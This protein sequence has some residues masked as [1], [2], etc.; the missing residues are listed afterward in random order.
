MVITLLISLYTTRVILQVLGEVDY[1][2]Y[3]VVCGFVLMFSFL[4]S[5]MSNGIQRFF[6][7]EYGKNGEA[8]ANRVYCT[9]LYIQT[10]LALIAVVIVE[11]VGLWYLHNKMVIPEERI[12]A[13]EWIFQLSII[14]FVIGIMQAPYMAAVIAHERMDFY[15]VVNVIETVLKLGVVFL[16]KTINADKLITYGILTTLVCFLIWASYYTYCKRNFNEITFHKCLDK[17][18][19]RQMLGFSGWNLFGSFSNMMRDQGINMI[20]NFFFGPSVNAARGV[21]MQVNSGVY[22]LVLSILTPVRPQVLQ[23]YAKGDNDRVMNLTYTI[24]KFSLYFLLL[25]AMPLC[26]EIDFILRIW[27][28]D[29]I[30][31]HT[32]AF[33]III[34]LTSAILIPTSTQATLVHATGKMRTYQVIGGIAKVLSV[35]IAFVMLK[36][37]Y[38]PEWALIMVLLFDFI[39]M[40]VGMF[41]IRTLMPF[42]VCKYV[43]KVFFPIIPVAT[44]AFL[45]SWMTHS[46]IGNEIL[47]FLLVTLVSTLVI[48]L[49]IYLVGM[50]KDEKTL[51]VQ[52]ANSKILRNS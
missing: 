36:M 25:L 37:G 52:L 50:T 27:L 16:L 6:N 21:A 11:A 42:R 20:L 39:G 13:A 49:M 44:F 38:A 12:V 18:I 35:P 23:S 34:L 46:F 22:G 17:S 40:I 33:V 19:F 31:Q 9:S 8:G 51:M 32:Q 5:S 47:R 45:S 10:L 41:I 28:G 1:G 15:A 7:I 4:N 29:N 2:V 14:M 3:N 43:K 30:P 48:S 24:S 26:V